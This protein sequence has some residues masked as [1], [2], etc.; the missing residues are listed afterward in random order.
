MSHTDTPLAPQPLAEVLSIY[1]LRQQLIGHV[2]AGLLSRA[3]YD[4]LF[5]VLCETHSLLP[6]YRPEVSRS[7]ALIAQLVAYLPQPAAL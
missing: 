5:E 3:D 2:R 6:W 7:V 1:Q 4:A